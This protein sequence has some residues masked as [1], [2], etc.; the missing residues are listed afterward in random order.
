MLSKALISSLTDHLLQ[1]VLVIDQKG[2]IVYCNDSAAQF[3][4]KD[5]VRLLGKQSSAL[6]HEDPLIKEKISGALE[7][8]KVFR[9]GGYVLQ[10]P[11]LQ[12]RGAEIVVA[13]VLNKYGHVKQAVITLLEST[14]LQESQAREQ[15]EQLARSL[16]TLAA[17]LAHEIQNPLGGVRGMLQLLERDLNKAK[18]KNTST[19]MMLAELD[20]VERLLKQLLLHSQPMPLEITQFDV[21]ELLNTVILFEQNTVSNIR[22]LRSFDTSLPDIQADCDKLHQVFLNLIRNAVEASPS[23]ATVT[24]RTRYCGKWELAGTNLNPE[25]NYMLISVEDEG[26]GVSLALR[27]QLFKPLFST[28]EK[29]HGLGLSISHRLIQ[30]HKGLLRYSSGNSAGAVFQIFLPHLQLEN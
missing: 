22:F 29:G 2:E 15:E 8:G 1:A 24:V 27:N 14:N 21:H 16:G 3:W 28:K 25:L 5:S 10:T 12:E 13:P 6:F 17:S 9:M 26:A 20:R 7:T 4:Q 18:I 23:A 11:P 19:G 30:A